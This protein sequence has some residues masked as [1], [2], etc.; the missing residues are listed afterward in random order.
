MTRQVFG[1]SEPVR[2]ANVRS[3][4]RARSAEFPDEFVYR[5]TPDEIREIA[6]Y[7][8]RWGSIWSCVNLNLDGSPVD[9]VHVVVVRGVGPGQA[10]DPDIGVGLTYPLEQEVKIPS[11]TIM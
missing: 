2:S 3:C 5:V 4:R 10:F 9:P 7:D 8:E 11:R 1:K 6:L